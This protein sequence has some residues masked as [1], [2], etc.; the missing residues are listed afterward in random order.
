MNNYV[1]IPT[2]NTVYRFDKAMHLQFQISNLK[3]LVTHKIRK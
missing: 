2:L 1:K 3:F